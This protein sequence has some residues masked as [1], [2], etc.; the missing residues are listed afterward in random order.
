MTSSLYAAPHLAAEHSTDPI[1]RTM[2]RR[3]FGLPSSST[4]FAGATFV[5]GQALNFEDAA[6]FPRQ[7]TAP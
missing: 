6:S 2:A 3:D 1:I 7:A 5:G 4:L